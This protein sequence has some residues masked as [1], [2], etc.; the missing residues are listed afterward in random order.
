[1]QLNH[2]KLGQDNYRKKLKHNF[3]QLQLYTELMSV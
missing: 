2:K 3:T 1:M